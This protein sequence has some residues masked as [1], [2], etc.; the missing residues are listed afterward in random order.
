MTWLLHLLG[1]SVIVGIGTLCVATLAAVLLD[2]VQVAE[3]KWASRVPLVAVT[4]LAMLLS[5]VLMAARFV[6]RA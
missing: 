4:G 2:Y 1:G 6:I 5:V 3:M